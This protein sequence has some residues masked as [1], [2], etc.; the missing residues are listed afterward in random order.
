MPADAKTVLIAAM[1]ARPGRV[2]SQETRP[3]WIPVE[4]GIPLCLLT[5]LALL[6][7]TQLLERNRE[8][9]PSRFV[10]ENRPG[11]VELDPKS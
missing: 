8:F 10:K 6:Y 7:V 5:L 11:R 1:G 3:G 4:L 9:R 2:G